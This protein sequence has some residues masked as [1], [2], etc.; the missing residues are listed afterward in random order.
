[1]KVFNKLKLKGRKAESSTVP[2]SLVTQLSI[3]R[4]D[5]LFAV[6]CAWGVRG[7]VVAAVL[8]EDR[9]GDIA[10]SASP[11]FLFEFQHA[12]MNSDYCGS[13]T[14]LLIRRPLDVQSLYPINHLRNFALQTAKS[15]F[16]FLVDVDC[17]PSS[18]T[19]QN[20]GGS[21]DS[22]AE[23][24]ETCVAQMCAI[25]VPCFET[26]DELT[27]PHSSF[28]E[29]FPPAQISN[30]GGDPVFF[31][32]DNVRN[33]AGPDASHVE[34]SLRPF[35]SAGFF[36]GHRATRF[37]Q[38]LRLRHLGEPRTVV[39][40]YPVV[41]EEG[42]EPYIVC[43]RAYAPKYCEALSGYGR[44]KTLHIYHMHRLGVTFIV[45]PDCCVVHIPHRSSGDRV[46]LLG[47]GG[48]G[49]ADQPARQQG[50]TSGGEEG[51]RVAT[52]VEG[53]LEG[54]KSVYA[55]HRGR[56]S[57]LCSS[58]AVEVDDAFW[59]GV[60]GSHLRTVNS[61]RQGLALKRGGRKYGGYP[62]AKGTACAWIQQE[63]IDML[64]YSGVTLESMS[65]SDSSAMI[66]PESIKGSA[67]SSMQQLPRRSW[68]KQVLANTFK[69][70]GHFTPPRLRISRCALLNLLMSF[71]RLTRL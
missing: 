51:P 26:N 46:R 16:V 31:T 62:R 4:I 64:Q 29:S 66:D 54:V 34:V 56:I 24:R 69:I 19:L 14:L 37:E 71:V 59:S 61:W 48:S 13:V 27:K 58:W 42:F 15:E 12:V 25:V 49:Q 53:M 60:D 52:K 55:E 67:D 3:D 9:S 6:C 50:T 45:H 35:M 36:R 22:L 41:Y 39:P 68:S 11:T 33:I 18:D 23:L 43:A 70:H 32:A 7:A 38:W 40:P 2:I 30:C 47:R 57:R 20:L 21:S 5:R 17:V 28:F 8:D 1:M 65:S 44:N 10:S 63:Y